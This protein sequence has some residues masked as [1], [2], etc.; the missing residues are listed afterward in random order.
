MRTQLTKAR[1]PCWHLRHRL[2]PRERRLLSGAGRR[3][4]QEAWDKPTRVA[5]WS[6]RGKCK[7]GQFGSAGRIRGRG[8]FNRH[9]WPRD[10]EQE[11]GDHRQVARWGQSGRQPVIQIYYCWSLQFLGQKDQTI[12]FTNYKILTIWISEL[13]LTQAG[14]T[15]FCRNSYP[16]EFIVCNF[17]SR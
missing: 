14:N 12:D 2:W 16:L 17:E 4:A 9:A 15:R 1:R 13:P 7:S 8:W 3:R 11:D 10:E 5:A 6:G